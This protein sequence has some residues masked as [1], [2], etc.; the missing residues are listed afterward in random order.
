VAAAKTDQRLRADEERKA[1]TIAK[2]VKE[3]YK[4]EGKRR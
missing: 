1:K 4:Y 3:Y 2:A